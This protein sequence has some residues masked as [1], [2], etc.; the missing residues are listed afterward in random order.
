M[1]K[2]FQGMT[3]D[4]DPTAFI[5]ETAVV[6]GDVAIGPESSV[7]Y[8]VVA[9]GDVNFIRIGARSNIQD[10]TMLPVTREHR[11]SSVTT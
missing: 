10:L 11:W 4:I 1:I 5:A 6:I 8:N 9:R 7:W 3:P 2:P